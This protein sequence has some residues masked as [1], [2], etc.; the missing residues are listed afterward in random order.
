MVRFVFGKWM[1][2]IVLMAGMA[3]SASAQLSGLISGETKP[4]NPD[5]A[6]LTSAEVVKSLPRLGANFTILAPSSKSYNAFGHVL[7]TTDRWI[8]P[9]VGSAEAP[10]QKIDELLS[11]S[12][13]RRAEGLNA[14]PQR[15]VQK[16]VVYGKLKPD[17]DIETVTAAAVQLADGTWSSKLGGAAVIGFDK[18]EQLTGPAYGAVVGIYERPTQKRPSPFVIR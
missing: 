8:N 3:G 10:L 17:G 13:Y 15:G 9:E 7:G 14:S 2:A 11:A 6:M 18:P 1:V 16:L 12:G 4:E 5:R